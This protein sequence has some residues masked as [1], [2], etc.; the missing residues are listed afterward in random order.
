MIFLYVFDVVCIYDKLQKWN[1]KSATW[2]YSCG[3]K[4]L[5]NNRSSKIVLNGLI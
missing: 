5:D 2:P 1:H 4:N 3:F